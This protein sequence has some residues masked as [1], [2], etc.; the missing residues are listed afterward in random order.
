MPGLKAVR[1]PDQAQFALYEVR[2][3][4]AARF[5]CAS[6]MTPGSATTRPGAAGDHFGTVFRIAGSR[7]DASIA[8]L[9]AKENGY[10]KIVSWQA[11]PEPDRTPAAAGAAGTRGRARS[12]PISRSCT[13][14]RASWKPG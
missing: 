7:K 14:P 13:R 8:L 11:E 3:D 9:W 1:H 6:R 5:D 4:V 2:D 12:R 10:W